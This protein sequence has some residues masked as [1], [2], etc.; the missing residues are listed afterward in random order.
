MR[1]LQK[2]VLGLVAVV[3]TAA[4]GLE[5]LAATARARL[6]RTWNV[7][8]EAVVVS[9]DA[10]SSERGARLA[11]ML[12]AN[13]HGAD[14]AGAPVFDDPWL[15]VIDAPNLTAGPGSATHGYAVE[16]W[17][18]AIRHGV[19]RD[20]NAL[21]VMPSSD[22][23]HLGAVD[24]GD[25]VSFLS[26]L[27]PVD[28]ETRPLATTHLGQALMAVGAFG[29]VLHAETIDHDQPIAGAQFTRGSREHGAYLVATLGCRSCHGEALAGGKDSN[30]DAPRGPDLR[31]TGP[32][33]GWTERD[34]HLALQTGQTPDGRVL[35][36]FMPWKTIGHA[37]EQELHALWSYLGSL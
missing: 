35:S 1:P 24:L 30:P 7:R 33:G 29:R 36:D 23:H 3:G 11:T 26:D 8:S 31:P 25:L 34:F 18:K 6:N 10:E 21:M 4:L 15:A 14:L 17:V 9:R 28:R 2:I 27:P 22:F 12:C 32:L 13:C 5:A 20:G 19:G 16:D 37:D